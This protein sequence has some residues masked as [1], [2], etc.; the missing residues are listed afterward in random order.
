M[1]RLLNE[2]KGEAEKIWKN[3]RMHQMWQ[4]KRFDK[5]I[6]NASMQAVLQRNSRGY[7]F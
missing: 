1:W 5:K 7:G 6:W 3:G 2:D 4:E